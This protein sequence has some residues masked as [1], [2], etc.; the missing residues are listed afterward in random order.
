MHDKGKLATYIDIT[1]QTIVICWIALF[2]FWAVKLFG[3]NFFEILVENENFVNLLNNAQSGWLRY[4]LSF[5]TISLSNYFFIGAILEKFVF[6]KLN[7]LIYCFSTVS[8]WII[9]NFVNID[10]LKMIY[11]YAIF[12][13][14]GFIFQK[15]LKKLYGVLSVALEFVFTTISILIRN[16][17]LFVQSNFLIAVILSIDVFIMAMLYYLYVNLIRLKEI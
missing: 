4:L 15:G 17:D 8:M 5:I 16:V 10:V 9:T 2:S 13:L 1:K 7:L 6:K 14:I 11:G 12:V 3:G